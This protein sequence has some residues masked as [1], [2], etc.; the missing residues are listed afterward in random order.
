VN[1]PIPVGAV[2]DYHGSLKHGRYVVTEHHDPAG[3]ANWCPQLPPEVLADA[4]PDG[5]AYV[6]W[7]EDV[8]VKFG[9]R[10]HAVYRVRRGSITLIHGPESPVA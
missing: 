9:L 3:A 4:Y 1:E 7:P 8:P 5:V 10:E 2:V 6:I